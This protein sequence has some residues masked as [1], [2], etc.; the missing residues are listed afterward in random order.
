V[1]GGLINKV[2]PTYPESAKLAHIEGT[3]VL[4]AT[5]SK[6]GEVQN[7]RALFG[8]QEL[9]PAAIAA[10]KQWRYEPFRLN[11]EPVEVDSEIRIDFTLP[12]Q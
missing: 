10:V 11:E 3:V 7:V 4:C 12:R 2:A 8:P 1:S 6:E 9:I 5:I